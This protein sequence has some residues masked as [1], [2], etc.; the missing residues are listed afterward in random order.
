M[1]LKNE[2]RAYSAARDRYAEFGVDTEKALEL[3]NS[4]PI[5]L[6]CW[7]GDDIQGF[8]CE[9]LN[10]EASGFGVSGGYPGKPRTIEELRQDLRAAYAL[11]PGKHR[12]NLHAIYAENGGNP[13]E[14]NELEPSHFRGWVEWAKQENLKIDLNATCF[15]HPRADSGFTLSHPDRAVRRFWIDHVKC[16]RKIA[17]SI[18]RELRSPCIH[19]L[20]IPDGCRE[21]PA[22]RWKPREILKNALDDIFSVDYSLS[23]MKDALESKLFG[24]GSES[25]VVGSHEFYLSYAL[26][27][28]KMIC[29]DLGHFH[30][31]ES[32]GDKISAVLQF[33]HD[34]LLHIS[35]GVRWN[36][37]HVVIFDDA[38]RSLAEEIVGSPGLDRV[39]IALDYF[40]KS[41][42]R[43]GAWVLGAR[44]VLKALLFALLLPR[45][46]IREAEHAGDNFRLLAIR[47]EAK[48]LPFGDV[49]DRHCGKCGVPPGD[50]WIQD[51]ASYEKTVLAERS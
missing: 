18:G 3:L 24:I 34:I 19:N 29:L 46:R 51:I 26:I 2:G 11:I 13:V 33:S 37:N 41:M 10:Q 23:Q 16:S 25:F 31:T 15:G 30:P 9:S 21:I 22:D 28:G 14:R 40:D 17:A 35:R 43:I 47:D 49:W 5:S 42:N 27:S 4:V 7:Q 6:H 39:H 20:W 12:L 36:N 50:R 45:D 48:S 1:A 38:I 8:E 44:A 32:V